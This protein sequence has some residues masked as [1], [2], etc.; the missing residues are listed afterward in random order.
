MSVL[1]VIEN[2]EDC[3]LVFSGVEPVPAR[4]YLT[5][6]TFTGLRGVKIINICRSYRYQSM[7]PATVSPPASMPSCA[8]V[9]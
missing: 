1:V 5:D 9:T 6:A 8:A 3:S 2:P 7:W 4:A